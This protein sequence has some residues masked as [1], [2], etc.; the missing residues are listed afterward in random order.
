MFFFINTPITDLFISNTEPLLAKKIAYRYYNLSEL[1]T[2]PTKLKM[3]YAARQGKWRQI[4]NEK[5]IIGNITTKCKDVEF[6]KTYFDRKTHR[7]QI[8]SM[9]STDIL[10]GYHGAAFV[11]IM[12]MMPYPGFIEVFSPLI[13]HQYYELMSK[14][15]QVAYRCLTRSTV[16]HTKEQPRDKRNPNIIVDVNKVVKYV[17]ELAEI[18]NKEKYKVVNVVYTCLKDTNN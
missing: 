2:K 16:D 11:N 13:R 7:S 4:L 6:E 1:I 8:L 5:A 12:F 15:T 3:L 10:F 17:N 14:K 18:V 9:R